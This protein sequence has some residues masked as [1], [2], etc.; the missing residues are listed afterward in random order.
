[1]P[2][3]MGTIGLSVER[4][5]ELNSEFVGVAIQTCCKTQ[6]SNR[7]LIVLI[8]FDPFHGI[9][10]GCSQASYRTYHALNDVPIRVH[11]RM[12]IRVLALRFFL[13]ET[14]EG[15]TINPLAQVTGWNNGGELT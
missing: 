10:R 14:Y 1:M 4:R 5:L 8:T 13:E 11:G 9:G 3:I 15:K 12:G 6:F 7:L 2:A